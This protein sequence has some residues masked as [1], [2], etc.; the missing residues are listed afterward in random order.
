MALSECDEAAERETEAAGWVRAWHGCKLEA[1]YSILYHGGFV[2]SRDR[3]QGERLL[4]RAPG[5]YV[6][7]DVTAQTAE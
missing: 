7:N 6:H 2:E 5:V 3:G 1:L 4:H